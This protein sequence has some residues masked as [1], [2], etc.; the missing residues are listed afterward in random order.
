[1]NCSV[2]DTKITVQLNYVP[3]QLQH[4][5]YS[6]SQFHTTKISVPQACLFSIRCKQFRVTHPAH[7]AQNTWL[8]G[9]GKKLSILGLM[10]LNCSLNYWTCCSSL[11]QTSCSSH[12]AFPA[13]ITVCHDKVPRRTHNPQVASHSRDTLNNLNRFLFRVETQVSR[14]FV[15]MRSAA[16]DGLIAEW[17]LFLSLQCGR[18]G[19]LVTAQKGHNTGSHNCFQFRATKIPTA[20]WHSLCVVK[21]LVMCIFHFS[22]FFLGSTSQWKQPLCHYKVAV[23]NSG[24]QLVFSVPLMQHWSFK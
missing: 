1:M 5:K 10:L 18:S 15:D 8:F 16:K 4:K 6:T 24:L 2:K 22:L 7:F 3:H 12:C 23:V 20:C 9:N 21:W 13:L 14:D 17:F 19:L 11:F